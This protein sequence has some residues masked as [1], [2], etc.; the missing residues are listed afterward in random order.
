MSTVSRPRR[1]YSFPV[2]PAI[3]LILF[4]LLFS[5][6]GCG[7]TE[8]PTQVAEPTEEPTQKVL[9]E[10]EEVTQAPPTPTPEPTPTEEPA[11][12]TGGPLTAKQ[13]YDLA[14]PIIQ[15][16]QPDAALISVGNT[17]AESLNVEDG[18]CSSW[19]VQFYSPSAGQVNNIMI[20]GGVPQPGTPVDG[21][22]QSDRTVD[23]STASF[24]SDKAIQIA[25]EAGGKA[26]ADEGAVVVMSY[27]YHVMPEKALWIINYSDPQS[28]MV[29]FSVQIDPESGQVVLAQKVE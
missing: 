9:E 2:A 26:Y 27:V 7:G 8:P 12:E 11:P 22:D 3:L 10:T 25:Q 16:W 4:A 15:S 13:A 29:K 17:I 14:L 6:S 19:S 20:V 23:I 28:Y 24:D 5:L 1:R 18:T 21:G